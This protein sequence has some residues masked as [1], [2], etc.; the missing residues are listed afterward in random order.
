MSRVVGADECG[1][2]CHQARANRQS[3]TRHCVPC[4]DGKC[5]KCGKYIARSQMEKHLEEHQA[6]IDALMKE[7][8]DQKSSGNSSSPGG[9]SSS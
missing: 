5:H 6:R 3:Q 7:Y 1:C 4:C 8:E 2:S 9:P